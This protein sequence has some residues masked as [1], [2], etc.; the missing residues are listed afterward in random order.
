MTK[1]CLKFN[2][3]DSK[4]HRAPSVLS[5]GNENWNISDKIDTSFEQQ[6]V[7]QTA[8]HSDC[9][10]LASLTHCEIAIIL[11]KSIE[12]PRKKHKNRARG[13]KLILAFLRACKSLEKLSTRSS[14]ETGAGSARPGGSDRG[15]FWET[16]AR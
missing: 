2:V 6:L 5:A 9:Y 10:S 13:E 3:H 4:L 1:S 7:L 15:R 16:V 11:S 14:Y 12:W 8:V